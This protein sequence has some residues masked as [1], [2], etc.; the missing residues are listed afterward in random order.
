MKED[1]KKWEKGGKSVRKMQ[2]HRNW[3][4]EGQD[5]AAPPTSQNTTKPILTAEI[6]SDS[7][8][9]E[10][11]FI[12]CQTLER[13]KKSTEGDEDASICKKEP[14]NYRHDRQKY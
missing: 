6:S 7:P 2:E 11:D 12:S 8:P 5:Q 13:K 1:C 9:C 14:K 4:R 3:D 10:C